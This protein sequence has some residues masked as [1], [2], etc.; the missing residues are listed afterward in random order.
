M[1]KGAIR[2][3]MEEGRKGDLGGLVWGGGGN[4]LPLEGL[5]IPAAPF[6]ARRHFYFSLR[7]NRKNE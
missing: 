7:M 1:N 5:V 6:G 2:R 4:Q 3:E